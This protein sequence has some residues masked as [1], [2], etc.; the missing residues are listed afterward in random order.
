MNRLVLTDDEIT[1]AL[2]VVLW[3]DLLEDI[4]GPSNTSAPQGVHEESFVPTRTTS[5]ETLA[6]QSNYSYMVSNQ[7]FD[8]LY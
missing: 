4:A 2:A 6:T 8:R 1:A 3:P 5:M 7:R